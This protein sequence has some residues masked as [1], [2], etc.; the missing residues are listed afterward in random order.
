MCF[1]LLTLSLLYKN[2]LK[3]VG[4]ITW[5]LSL[6]STF[7]KI[8]ICATLNWQM[9][10][11]IERMHKMYINNSIMNHASWREAQNGKV[12]CKQ[13]ILPQTYF[14]MVLFRLSLIS[15]LPIFFKQLTSKQNAR[16]RRVCRT[17]NKKY[18]KKT[19]CSNAALL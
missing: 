9:I 5:L 2:S 18:R 17:G 11:K 3:R 8:N 19:R 1:H 15:F 7:M 4:K 10:H 12:C 6:L 14:H 16:V 13:K